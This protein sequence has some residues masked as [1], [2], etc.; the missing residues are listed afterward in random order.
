MIR[1][2]RVKQ[3]IVKS[4]ISGVTYS[5]NP[6]IG[7]AHGCIYCYADF[8]G[9][10]RNVL[11]W[12]EIIEVKINL[13]ERLSEEIKR[14]KKGEICLGTV[15]DPY[16]PIEEKYQL[17]RKTIEI[18]KDSCFPFTILTKSSLCLRDID[19]LA[20]HPINREIWVEMT[21]TTLDER[22]RKI[23]EP[24]SSSVGERIKALKEL[25]KA[26]IKTTLFF[27]PVLPY[28][29]DK[30][31]EIRNVFRLGA[32]VGVEEIL[33]DRLNYLPQKLPKIKTA[34]RDY[35]E[36]I[37][38]YERIYQN[39]NFYTKVLKEKIERVAKESSLPIRSIFS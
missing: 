22:V 32:E 31:E 27:G 17:T 11:P 29:S 24:N 15:C 4:G 19:L 2:I 25:K 8:I 16:Q 18:L 13:L 39:Y 6:Y 9:R 36:A 33:V 3:A 20:N 38:Y 34:L 7:C 23:F 28:F 26:K 10:W 5:L 21:L 35:P 30:E 37:R 12:G 1:E 14:K